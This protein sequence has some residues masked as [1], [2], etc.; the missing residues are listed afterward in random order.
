MSARRRGDYG[1]ATLRQRNRAGSH[2]RG[3]GVD[4]PAHDH[5]RHPC[6]LLGTRGPDAAK[7]WLVGAAPGPLLLVLLA[8]PESPR[9]TCCAAAG[10]VPNDPTSGCTRHGETLPVL[11]PI[12]AQL[13]WEHL[14]T[15]RN[16]MLATGLFAFTNLSGIEA[17]LCYAPTIATSIARRQ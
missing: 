17:N 15:G 16:L 9:G 11:E 1:R 10:K 7:A 6:L 2:A 4:R 8:V 12:P 3:A 13:C 5:D 14:F